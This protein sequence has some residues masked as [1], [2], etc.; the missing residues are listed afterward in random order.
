LDGPNG[1]PAR[2]TFILAVLAR[3]MEWIVE[4]QHRQIETEAVLPPIDP[5]LAIIPSE[6]HFSLRRYRSVYTIRLLLRDRNPW[7]FVQFEKNSNDV[8]HDWAG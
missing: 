6:F 3:H 4:H 8:L 1:L 7:G 2:F 5:V